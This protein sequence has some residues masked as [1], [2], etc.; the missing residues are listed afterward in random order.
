MSS[1]VRLG[2]AFVAM[3]FLGA[4][5]DAGDG[6]AG[7]AGAVT[8]QPSSSTTAMTN[9]ATTTATAATVPGRRFPPEAQ[10]RHGERFYAVFVAVERTSSAPELARAKQELWGFTVASAHDFK[11]A[12]SSP[13][14]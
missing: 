8:S 7:R 13:R 10:L 12:F 1:D 6:V 4:C 3:L 11:L 5:E 14:R 2:L 9:R